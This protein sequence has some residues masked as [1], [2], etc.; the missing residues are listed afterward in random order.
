MFKQ[1]VQSNVPEVF[2]LNIPLIEGEEPVN[3]EVA[4]ILEASGSDVLC[5]L[6]SVEGAEK[7]DEIT[8]DLINKE[9]EKIQE[10]TTVIFY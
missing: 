10:A 9:V 3:I 5:Y 7:I 8:I 2:T 1:T 4:V 6:E